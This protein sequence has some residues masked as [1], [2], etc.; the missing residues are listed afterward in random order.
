ML[1]DRFTTRSLQ[2]ANHMVMAPMTRNRAT[3][4]HTP[5]A[6]MATYYGQRAT[7]G[8]II[9]EGTSPSPNGLG[10]PRI[11]GLYDAAQVDAWKATTSA[12]HARAATRQAARSSCS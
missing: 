3:P 5:V 11:P 2:L 12:V 6:L 10:Y 7:A 4:Q 1:F 9:T 8:L